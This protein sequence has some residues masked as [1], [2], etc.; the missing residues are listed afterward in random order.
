MAIP[1]FSSIMAKPLFRRSKPE[2]GIKLGKSSIR[3]ELA[4]SSFAKAKGLMLRKTIDSGRGMLFDFGA[5]TS[6]SMW[7]FG[8]LFPIDMLWL[9]GG[10]RIVHIEKSCQPLRI[11]KIYTPKKKARYVL[12]VKS[13]FCN[14]NGINEG[15]YASFC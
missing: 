12:E 15:Q 10:F 9:D 14:E 6:P 8:M 13:G 7:M 3:A 1:L 4:K 11:W 2:V 5:E